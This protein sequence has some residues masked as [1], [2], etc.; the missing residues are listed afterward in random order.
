MDNYCSSSEDEGEGQLE[1]DPGPPEPPPLPPLARQGASRNTGPKGV[2]QD[3]TI[4]QEHEKRKL[5]EK[6]NELRALCKATALTCLSEREEESLK[7]VSM[8]EGEEDLLSDETLKDFMKARMEQMI[9][10][11]TELPEFG[12]IEEVPSGDEYLKLIDGTNPMIP[13]VVHIYETRV[14]ECIRMNECLSTLSSHYRR[15]RF[16]K[17]KASNLG[18]TSNFK[19]QGVPALLVYKGGSLIGNFVALKEEFGSEFYEGDVENYLIENGMLED[20]ASV[21]ALWKSKNC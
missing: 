7:A 16:C 4:F 14:P 15:V 11:K 17:I 19:K 6:E 21:P 5:T 13:V 8:E 9:R 1:P 10:M 18:V 3:W 20:K 12:E 2:L